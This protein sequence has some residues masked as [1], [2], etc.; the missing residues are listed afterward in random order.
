MCSK[1][2]M[3]CADAIFLDDEVLGAKIGDGLAARVGEDIDPDEIDAGAERRPLLTRGLCGGRAVLVEGGSSGA[4]PDDDATMTRAILAGDGF[5]LRKRF[6]GLAVALAEAVRRRLWC[7][8]KPAPT[9]V[10]D[11]I[12]PNE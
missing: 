8:L 1:V 6:G 10:Q 12:S 11:S 4:E 3:D 7:W 2:E 5:R 9:P